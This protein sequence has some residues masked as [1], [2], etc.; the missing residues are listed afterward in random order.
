[1]KI[2]HVFQI[3]LSQ[4][5]YENIHGIINLDVEDVLAQALCLYAKRQ[6]YLSD[7]RVTNISK[8]F[9]YKMAAK[10]IW[11][12]YVTKLRHCH[13]MWVSQK[14]VHFSTHHNYLWNRLR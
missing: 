8:S 13:P 6:T 14:V 4:L 12:R 11:H 9:T 3:K 7:S 5:V 1:M 2:Y 10:T